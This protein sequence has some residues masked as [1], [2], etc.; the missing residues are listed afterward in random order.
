[1]KH[2]FVVLIAILFMS[3]GNEQQHDFTLKGHV[4]GLKK[5]SVYLQ[6]QQDSIMITLDSLEINGDSNFELHSELAEPEILFLK[7]NKNDNDEGTVV[8]F[9][10]KGVT[11]I[12]STLKNFN[13]DAKI[14]GSKQHDILEEYLEVMSKFNDENLEL[15][16]STLEAQKANDTTANSFDTE[17]N[18]LLKRK[19]LYTIN[20]AV[21]HPDSEV[22]PYL[23]ISE[24]PNT[25]ITFLQQI[26]DALNSDIKSSK[27]GVKLSELIEERHQE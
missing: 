12:N 24:V 23:A 1:M 25:S 3:C 5:G 6:K 26:Y 7:L 9:A 2:F 8:F 17:Y 21:N 27:Y 19:Y 16:Q 18:K 13:F 10:D 15:I 20:F 22:A 11:E 14:K 4:K